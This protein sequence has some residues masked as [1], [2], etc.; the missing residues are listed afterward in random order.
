M[1][2]D[3]QRIIMEGI[4]KL[5]RQ[6]NL[7]FCHFSFAL[8]GQEALDRIETEAP[9]AIITDIRMP[10]M[11]GLELCQRIRERKD[12]FREIPILILTG[13][14]EFEYARK[15]I[16]HQVLFYLLKPVGKEELYASCKMMINVLEERKIHLS[17]KA[18]RMNLRE[19]IIRNALHW[20]ENEIVPEEHPEGLLLVQIHAGRELRGFYPKLESLR[21]KLI[22]PLYAAYVRDAEAYFL[23][24]GEKLEEVIE[25][26][27]EINLS[28]PFYN[29]RMLP[30]AIRQVYQVHLRRENLPKQRLVSYG[31]IQNAKN[32]LPL[33]SFQDLRPLWSA[34]GQE[35][36]GLEQALDHIHGQIQEKARSSRSDAAALYGAVCMEIYKRYFSIPLAREL[37]EEFDFLLHSGALLIQEEPE[38]MKELVDEKVRRIS[39]CLEHRQTENM[40]MKAKT[41]IHDAPELSLN[42]LA[43]K[44]HIS[45]QY[46]S[47]LF[48]K[49]TGV[50]LGDYLI[51][52]RIAKACQLLKTT[53]MTVE[54]VAQ[55]IG[56]TSEKHFFVVFK[57]NMGVSPAR[58]RKENQ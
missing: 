55:E 4:A 29:T 46:L 11:D 8:N 13:Y 31:D 22:K 6:M 25:E 44:L 47:T 18:S 28:S 2:V 45:S 15:A 9:D 49:E 58:Y 50:A 23:L 3:D 12:E 39:G 52:E 14:D 42:G 26:D 19:H 1:L 21:T 38:R 20:S 10:V 30:E 33:I 48:H 53:R 37:K 41:M 16:R 24:M 43:Q 32:V 34:M 54:Q 40:I 27:L 17:E 35:N 5:I 56:Y 7:P 51:Q 36:C 57:K